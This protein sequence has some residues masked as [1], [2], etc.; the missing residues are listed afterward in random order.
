MSANTST[1]NFIGCKFCDWKTL[2]FRH[3]KK[4]GVSGPDKAYARLLDHIE[5]SH[6]DKWVEVESILNSIAEEAA[7]RERYLLT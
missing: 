2:K 6:P 1:R 7:D 4:G 5:H 3:L